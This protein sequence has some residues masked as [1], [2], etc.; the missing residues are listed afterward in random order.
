MKIIPD[1]YQPSEPPSFDVDR[2]D[3]TLEASGEF[4]LAGDRGLMLLTLPKPL[5]GEQRVGESRAIFTTKF[6]KT[7][8][9]GQKFYGLLGQCRPSKSLRK[10]QNMYF[11]G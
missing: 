7:F 11:E 3:V 6:C 4:F 8:I 2:L 5:I 10:R 9:I 1:R